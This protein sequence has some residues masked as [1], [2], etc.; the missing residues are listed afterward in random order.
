[1]LRVGQNRICTPYMAVCM[2][3][4]LPKVPYIRRIY[5]CMVLAN[6]MNVSSDAVQVGEA[7]YVGLA[8]T[9]YI[10]IYIYVCTYVH[11]MY[12]FR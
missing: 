1:M 7:L 5:V 2:V 10:Y 6:H 8:R 4:S 3:I 11:C 12:V 9:I